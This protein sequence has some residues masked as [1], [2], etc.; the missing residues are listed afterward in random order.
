MYMEKC[1]LCDLIKDRSQTLWE[2]LDFIVMFNRYP[3]KFGHIMIVPKSHT[4]RLTGLPQEQRA[5]FMEIIA[6]VSDV[7]L[8][9]FETDSV[10]HGINQGPHS[11]ASLPEHIHY[12]L[13]PRKFNDT[14]FFTLVGK[15]STFRY[16]DQSRTELFEQLSELLKK[17]LY[18]ESD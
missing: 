8:N 1:L 2:N 7:V 6:R 16:H 17:I 3:Y 12:H 9:F 13:I 18:R 14:G 10:N 4:D 11:G 15:D 5:M